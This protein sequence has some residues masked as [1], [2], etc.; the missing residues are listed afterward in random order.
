MLKRNFLLFAIFVFLFSLSIGDVFAAKKGTLAQND[1]EG[2]DVSEEFLEMPSSKPMEP[3]NR[4]NKDEL[5]NFKREM[6]DV[7]KQV[8]DLQKQLKGSKGMEEWA[9]TLKDL[10]VKIG[11]CRT[12]VSSTPTDD[13]RDFMDDCRGNNFWDTINDIR[14]EFVPPQD[15]KNANRDITRQ[16]KDLNKYKKTLSKKTEMSASLQLVEDLMKLVT[17]HKD[18]ITNS[19]GR[20]QR[21]A[22]NDFW[23]SNGD[24]NE[25]M[26]K[27]RAMIELPKEMKN[28]SNDMKFVLKEA[29]NK[30]MAKAYTFFGVD[31][32]K[33][34]ELLNAKKATIDQISALMAKN[35]YDEAMELVQEEIHQGWH[36]GDARHLLGMTRETYD[37]L[38]GVKD[39]KLKNAVLAVVGPILE[40]FIAGDVRDARD[41]MVQFTDQMRKYERFFRPS[42]NR[43]SKGL[44][45]N[46]LKALGKVE[47][48]IQE[49]IQGG[50]ME[51]DDGEKDDRGEDQDDEDNQML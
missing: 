30:T 6:S 42:Y 44:D 43:G 36:P 15:I 25:E 51:K 28:I 33:V 47:S 48:L 50:E 7:S 24:L 39:E 19:K 20:D 41:A 26:N 16:L 37:R 46:M 31:K 12:K 10:L 18:A 1:L 29:S 35:T 3:S 17:S 22:L 11:E 13:Q 2:G 14:E 40:G 38:R 49:K 34:I 8:K 4:V 32:E 27:I 5:N 45:K 21:D 23:S 9:A